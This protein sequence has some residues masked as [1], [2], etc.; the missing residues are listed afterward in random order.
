MTDIIDN[1][2][3]LSLSIV[4]TWSLLHGMGWPDYPSSSVPLGTVGTWNRPRLFLLP[5][6]FAIHHYHLAAYRLNIQVF[7]TNTVL[8]LL[9]LQVEV[10]SFFEMCV[11]TYQKTQRHI[12]EYL[13][14]WQYRWEN[15]TSHRL[16]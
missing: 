5:L 13:D 3:V 7:R 11:T 4:F 2:T 8:G 16:I 9:K 1:I 14:I 10:T 6:K 12:P 15:L